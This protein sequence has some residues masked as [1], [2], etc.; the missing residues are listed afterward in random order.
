MGLIFIARLFYLQ[1]V[2]SKYKTSANDNAL[3]YLTTYPARGLIYDRAGKLLVYN[4]ATYDLMV[5]PKELDPQMDTAAFCALTGI[6]KDV[7]IKKL[8]ASRQY[9]GFI[10]SVIDEKIPPELY[11]VLQEKLAAFPGFFIQARTIR[12]YTQ[13]IAAH[14]LGYIG[15]ITPEQLEQDDYYRPG[16]YIGISGLERSYEKELRGKKGVRIIM[17]DVNGQEKGSY[18]QGRMDV[19]AMA[20][21]DL[22]TSIETDLQAYGEKLMKNKRGSVVVMEPETGE[23]LAIVTSPNYDPGLL[24]GRERAKNYFELLSDKELP[25]FNRAL[26]G[27]YP[28]GSTFKTA[29]GL[30]GQ[31]EGVLSPGTRYPC[32][33]GF[34]LGNGKKVG[35]HAHGGPLDLKGAIQHSC[36]AYFCK[37]FKTCIDNKSFENPHEALTEWRRLMQ[38]LALGRRT[39]ID[40]PNES[41]G[42]IPSAEYYDKMWGKGKWRALSIISLGIGQGEILLTPLQMA[43]LTCI[44]AN[45]GTYYAPHIVRAIGDPDHKNPKYLEKIETGFNPRYFDAIIQGMYY[46]VVSGTAANVKIDD[47]AVCGKTGT[48]QNAGKNHSIF[49]AFAPMQHP[50]IVVAAVVENSGAGAEWAAPIAS[51]IIEHYL[52]GDTKRKDMEAGIINSKASE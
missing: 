52:T 2:E 16:D 36:N 8:K 49:I 25:L 31:Y 29:V 47:I 42:N 10:P 18:L 28:P 39:G 12:N 48:A 1:I 45:R 30:V 50:K 6:E 37:V 15:E 3:R 22:Y 38:K 32:Y 20:G 23:V 34:P 24:A 40:L 7:L 46:V 51:L 19:Q 26:N 4:E 27:K 43:N 11:G 14:M 21:A 41:S 33:G 35:C 13:P 17:V 44:I 9:S 5:T